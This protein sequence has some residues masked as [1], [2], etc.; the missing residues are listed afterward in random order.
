MLVYNSGNCVVTRWSNNFSSFCHSIDKNYY[1]VWT[2]LIFWG[3]KLQPNRD[4]GITHT[5]QWERDKQVNTRTAMIYSGN[6]AVKKRLT[7]WSGCLFQSL[8]QK[9][10][11]VKLHEKRQ[12]VVGVHK[13]RTNW[14]YTCKETDTRM[15][16][17]LVFFFSSTVYL[18]KCFPLQFYFIL[19]GGLPLPYVISKMQD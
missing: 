17:N 13:Q 4:T 2:R 8:Q 10:P 16:R 9:A 1:R 6:M 11:A 14:C 5:L 19:H 7:L 12:S 3:I 18:S 15:P